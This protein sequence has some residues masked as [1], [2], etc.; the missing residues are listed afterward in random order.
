LNR[1]SVKAVVALAFIVAA[2]VSFV[3][4]YAVD[5]A[6]YPLAL[7]ASTS[8]LATLA[9]LLRLHF[10]R[11]RVPDY[12]FELSGGYF[13]RDGCCF[14]PLAAIHDGILWFVLIYQNKYSGECETRVSIKPSMKF[15]MNRPA[16]PRV[17]VALQCGSG[18]LAQLTCP[19]WYQ[20]NSWGRLNKSTLWP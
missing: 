16:L 13:E 8:A 2:I 4:W 9:L 15:L 19:G 10:A 14:I 17:E 11:D 5:E 20:Q 7:V 18:A 3:G 1:E 6:G 12:L